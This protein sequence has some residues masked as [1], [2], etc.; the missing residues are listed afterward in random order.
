MNVNIVHSLDIYQPR[1]Q[2]V[3]RASFQGVKRFGLVSDQSPS[4]TVEVQSDW[5]ENFAHPLVFMAAQ[6]HSLLG[7]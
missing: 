7:I 2:W 3:S 6:G 4:Y 1:V 5:N